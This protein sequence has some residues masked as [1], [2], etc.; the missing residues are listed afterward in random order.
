MSRDVILVDLSDISADSDFNCRDSVNMVA[1]RALAKSILEH[2]REPG[3][4][5]EDGSKQEEFD[6]G[7]MQPV[8]IRP[9]GKDGKKY[10]LVAGYR[11]TAAF[12]M[13]AEEDSR[14]KQI[15]AVVKQCSP[16][17]AFRMNLTEN[18]Q[19]KEL[20][21]KEESKAVVR[22]IKN[23]LTQQS[24]ADELGVSR[25]WVQTRLYLSELPDNVQDQVVE[26]KMNDALIH[27]LWRMPTDEEKISSVAKYKEKLALGV[28][29]KRLKK[30]VRP[31]NKKLI[32]NKSEIADKM[33]EVADLL[34]WGV[35]TRCMA[36]I[37]GA[38]TDGVLDS[39]L[40]EEKQKQERYKAVF[41]FIKAKM[42]NDEIIVID[43][44][45]NE[46]PIQ[47]FD[48]FAWLHAQA[49]KEEAERVER[50]RQKAAAA[51]MMS[52]EELEEA[53][54]SYQDEAL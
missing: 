54:D 48:E 44:E 11:R 20:N 45:G 35:T 46:T 30:R 53:L 31:K 52:N 19:R 14:Y 39:V 49:E 24:T 50:E 18:I 25:F 4:V 10:Q 6:P 47:A 13:L 2:K 27:E 22:L 36:W 12:N 37:T 29:P 34:G 23:G 26:L 51:E 16:L 33:Q 9:Y 43:D 42:L 28:K 41:S 15:P 32:P 40:Q 17:E 8:V 21:R 1:I 7:L 5:H 3:Y 38:I